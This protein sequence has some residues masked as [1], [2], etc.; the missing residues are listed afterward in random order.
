MKTKGTLKKGLSEAEA[1]T[2][3]RLLAKA[4]FPL[5]RPVFDGWVENL[6]TVALELA[7]IRTVDS[8]RREIF[9]ARRGENDPFWPGEWHI[10]GTIVRQNE[11]IRV[12]Y[13]R[14]IASEASEV[15]AI[16]QLRFVTY[17][18]FPKGEGPNQCKRGHEIG[19]LH[20]VELTRGNLQGGTF[21]PLTKIP[22]KTI[23]FHRTMV[24]VVREFLAR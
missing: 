7:F 2:L 22:A 15:N 8:G 3:G 5:P 1:K 14:L 12:A 16:G 20:L 4:Q 24:G 17:Q 13:Q 10:P 21:F 11:P 6:P 9:M 18:E 23:G 19:L